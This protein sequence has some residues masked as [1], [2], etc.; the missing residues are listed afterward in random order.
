[1]TAPYFMRSFLAG[2]AL[3]G[4]VGDSQADLRITS[5]P[6]FTQRQMQDAVANNRVV[7]PTQ[8]VGVARQT[9]PGGDLLRALLCSDGEV[10]LYVISVLRKDGRVVHVIVDGPSGTVAAVQ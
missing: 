9:V 10:Y 3:L 1:M 5:R 8:A 7:R 4:V 6:C 2:L